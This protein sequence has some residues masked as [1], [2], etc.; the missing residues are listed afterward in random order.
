[1]EGIASCLIAV[2]AFIVLIGF[3]DQ[4]IIPSRL[5]ENEKEGIP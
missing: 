1:M 2:V 4:G 3:P 5:Q